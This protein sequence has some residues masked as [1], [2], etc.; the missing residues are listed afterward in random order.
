MTTT[1]QSSALWS[2]C[3][4]S[5]KA[6]TICYKRRLQVSQNVGGSGPHPGP[7]GSPG[8]P[9]LLPGPTLTYDSLTVSIATIL[10]EQVLC[11]GTVHLTSRRPQEVSTVLAV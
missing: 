7:T 8:A 1:Q 2:R 11:L 4:S 3:A 5:T 6:W 10:Q 9:P